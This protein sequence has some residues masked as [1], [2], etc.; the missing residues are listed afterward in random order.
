MGKQDNK[1]STPKHVAFATPLTQIMVDKA[2]LIIE[3][4][5]YNLMDNTLTTLPLGPSIYSCDPMLFESSITRTSTIT[6]QPLLTS[7]VRTPKKKLLAML[8]AAT[9]QDSISSSER[10]M[11]N[12][13]PQCHYNETNLEQPK[14]DNSSAP[15]TTV[16]VTDLINSEV[17]A[18]ETLCHSDSATNAE[19]QIDS[20]VEP[21]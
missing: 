8:D 4:S 5:S 1:R 15:P 10:V 7:P 14:T 9:S 13:E 18:I 21:V 19:V 11:A 3:D 20:T 17:A 6:P 16:E 12:A 2:K